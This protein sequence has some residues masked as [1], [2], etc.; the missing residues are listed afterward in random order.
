MG[1]RLYRATEGALTCG[2]EVA[3]GRR[4]C[5]A[6]AG[7]GLE[8][9]SGSRSGTTPTGETH[10]LASERRGGGRWRPGGPLGRGR[11][12]R[13]NCWAEPRGGGRRKERPAGLGRAGREGE[14]GKKKREWAGPKEKRGR[15]KLHSNI[16]KFEFKFKI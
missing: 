16:F 10:L 11:E 13:S 1:R 9:K 3:H 7:L 15:K 2:L 6:V 8:P 14:R 4:A 12:E 5:C